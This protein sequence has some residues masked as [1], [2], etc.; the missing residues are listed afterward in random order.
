MNMKYLALF[1]LFI[2]S[3]T[4]VVSQTKL[5]DSLEQQLKGAKQADR[6]RLLGDL[7]WEFSSRDVPKAIT[8]ANQLLLEAEKTKDSTAIAEAN[9][10]A[11]VAYYRKGDYSRA[12]TLNR[13]AYRIRKASG[14]L[15]AIGSSLNKFVNIYTDQVL[16]DS[17]M[18][19][20]L[21][22]VRIYEQ[23]KDTSSLALSLNTLANIYHKDRDFESCKEF[24][25]RAFDLSKSIGFTYGWAGAAGNIAAAEQEVEHY[26]EAL[27][28]YQQAEQGFREIDSPGDLA[29]VVSNRGYIFS[30][31]GK[32][33]D[34]EKNYLEA[35]AWAQQMGESSGLSMYR[36]NL[37]GIYIRQKKYEAAKSIFE[38]AL[39]TAEHERL[40][41]I[42][43][44][45]YDGL[46]TANAYLGNGSAA[47]DYLEKYKQLRDEL[48]N[49]DRAKQLA[50]MRTVYETE[51]KE[52]ENNWLK[53]ENE[54]KEQEKKRI[55]LG[56]GILAVLLLAV[57]TLVYQ[58][59]R[60][61]QQAQ[62][63]S[64]LVKERE[65]GLAAV[66]EGIE[67]E[68][69]RIAKDLHD[70][71]GQQLSGLRMSWEALKERVTPA[72]PEES[73]RLE[74][75]TSVLDESAKELRSISHQMMP[76]AIEE[77]GLLPALEEMLEKSLGYT[78]IH[79]RLE[80]FQVE[81]K[82]F[83]PRIEVG[84]Y[85]VAQELVNNVVKH[86]HATEVSVQLYK[87]KGFLILIVEDNG[88]GF[89]VAA[90]SEGIGLTNI[91]SRINTVNG[92][93][94]WEPGPNSGTVATIR[95]PVEGK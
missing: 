65:R 84:L 81:G 76:R 9:N 48:Y 52:Q 50:E 90:R 73:D 15:A 79:F 37:G 14:N 43:L 27:R 68:R 46:A 83:D 35:I 57:V 94:Q 63:Q 51:K 18:H 62:Y 39:S 3:T 16:L 12:L 58:A 91:T 61:K 1:C 95:V 69:K 33:N 54:R 47:S 30:K 22:A 53:S 42:Q 19:Y 8:Y 32:L 60:N 36:A 87:S 70:G 31:Q 92:D 7:T 5:T 10:L 59:K 67:E 34:A 56:L 78:K 86:S 29:T 25:K 41:R 24:S 72:L 93:V 71:I 55:I 44:Q 4:P 17:A 75:L 85:R 21:E 89:E 74:K 88:R 26:E 45:C 40:G 20:G 28:W 23:L 2:F 77:N 64:N 49:K 11:S 6:L 38:E 66:F 80:H 13:R 82:R